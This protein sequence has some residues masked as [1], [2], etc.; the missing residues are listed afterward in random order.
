MWQ[1]AEFSGC[2]QQAALCTLRSE[3]ARE[4]GYQG[5]RQRPWERA[6]FCHLR[7]LA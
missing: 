6:E 2:K 4:G 7:P 5:R 3:G 1:S